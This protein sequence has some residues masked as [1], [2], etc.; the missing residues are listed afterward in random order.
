MPLLSYLPLP[1]P[2]QAFDELAISHTLPLL[3]PLQA[4]EE[5]AISHYLALLLSDLLHS[6]LRQAVVKDTRLQQEPTSALSYRLAQPG[7]TLRRLVLCEVRGFGGAGLGCRLRTLTPHAVLC[8]V[9]AG[10]KGE[11]RVAKGEGRGRRDG[12][13]W[14]GCE[15]GGEHRGGDWGEVEEEKRGG[16]SGG[17]LFLRWRERDGVIGTWAHST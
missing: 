15:L 6:G 14:G 1:P 2:L 7:C 13:G 11:W 9:M 12:V 3:L 17:R 5:L 8:E 16:R 4:F 10:L